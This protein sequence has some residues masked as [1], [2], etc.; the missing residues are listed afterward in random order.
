MD[1]LA[2]AHGLIDGFAD[3]GVFEELA[4]ADRFGHASEVLIH[5]AAGAQVHVA[6]F[7]VAHLP[8]R[9][10]DIHAGPGDQAVRH[11]LVQAIKD[12]H[13][14]CVDRIAVVAVAVTEA[15]KDD[16]NQ[17]FRRGSHESHSWLIGEVEKRSTV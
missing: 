3:G 6:D 17:R 8:V 13:L 7:G 9:Q 1:G 5:H 16:Q 2:S 12:R 4:V 11:G 10:T 14:R 15:V